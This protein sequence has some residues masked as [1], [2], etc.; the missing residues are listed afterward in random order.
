VP[1]DALTTG[2]T[3]NLPIEQDKLKIQNLGTKDVSVAVGGI[4]LYVHP[5]DT[6]EWAIQYTSFVMTG[7]GITVSVAYTATETGNDIIQRSEYVTAH[8]KPVVAVADAAATLT[9]AQIVANSIFTQTPTLARTLTTD[10]GSAIIAALPSYSIGSCVEFTIVNP[11]RSN[12]RHNFSG[13]GNRSNFKWPGS[14]SGCNKWN[15][16]MPY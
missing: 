7:L 10:I 12:K 5:G 8:I 11:S 1:A 2:T 9:A 6:Q 4:T 14:N 3:V 13:R 16:Y 15:V